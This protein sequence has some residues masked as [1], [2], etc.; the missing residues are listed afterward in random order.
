MFFFY[1]LYNF[2]EIKVTNLFLLSQS[3]TYLT[4]LV[5][6]IWLADIESIDYLFKLIYLR[7]IAK[8]AIPTYINPS[9]PLIPDGIH[10]FFCNEV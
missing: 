3:E 5:Y 2:Q 10:L 9:R 4:S 1:K 6:L 8:Q 7:S